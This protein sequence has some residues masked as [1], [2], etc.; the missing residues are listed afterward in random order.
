MTLL[1]AILKQLFELVVTAFVNAEF[2]PYPLTP[3]PF[4]VCVQFCDTWSAFLGVFSFVTPVLPLCVSSF[5][6]PGLPLCVSSFVTPGL[7]LCVSSFVTPV[8]PLCVSSFVT[9]DLPLCVSSFVTPG[10]VL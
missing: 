1:H 9:P 10:L 2:H 8:L 6:T 3:V 5:V 7:P 4:C